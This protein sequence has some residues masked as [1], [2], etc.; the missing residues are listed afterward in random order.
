MSEP[1]PEEVGR[2]AFGGA[3]WTGVAGLFTRGVALV[4]FIV[5]GRAL[6]PA[7]FGLV[8]LAAGIVAILAVVSDSG[9]STYI[10]RAEELDD[11][12]IST[13]YWT[14]LMVSAALFVAAML[15][16]P[17]IG[18]LFGQPDLVPIVRALAVSLL[19]T[20]AASIPAALLR[21]SFAFGQLA[22][23]DVLAA[24]VSAVAGVTAALNG[25]GA[26]ALVIQLL[27]YN[28]TD[29]TA[30]LVLSRFRPKARIV[31]GLLR[32]MLSFGA[33]MLTVDLLVNARDRGEEFILGL[34]GSAMVGKWSA[35]TRLVSYVQSVG[36][37][38]VSAVSTTTLARLQSD[39]DRL[40]RGYSISMATA[41]ALI[42][43]LLGYFFV[44]S[45]QLVPLLLGTQWAAISPI[46]AIAALSGMV[47]VFSYFD[48]SMFAVIDRLDVEVLLVAG[49]VAL[50]LA[51]TVAAAPFGLVTLAIALLV[52]NMITVPVRQIVLNRYVGTTF[53]TLAP[54]MRVLL[55]AVIAMGLGYGASRLLSTMGFGPVAVVIGVGALFLAGYAGALMLVARDVA[56]RV[57]RLSIA[58]IRRV[59]GTAR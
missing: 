27:T 35:S 6:E 20:G 50:H 22:V 42:Y 9:L 55:A 11:A 47:A 41:A 28:A 34:M 21:R 2:L 37:Q 25:L 58:T 49:I 31:P 14:S 30:I 8:A 23:R 29:M 46:A 17:G 52:K 44:A 40:V 12:T 33:R 48:R 45:D 57:H 56:G 19:L 32:P 4:T 53:A 16:A 3:I 51:V 7:A 10:V 18:W 24:T 36:T 43:P 54:T 38:I 1:R 59:R 15:V 13:A 39:R 5:I 26:W